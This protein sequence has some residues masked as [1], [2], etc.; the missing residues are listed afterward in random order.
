MHTYNGTT[1]EQLLEPLHKPDE[2]SVWALQMLCLASTECARHV[3]TA[4]DA[5]FEMHAP[6]VQSLSLE[7]A[8]VT[9]TALHVLGVPVHESDVQSALTLQMLCLASTLCDAQWPLTHEP[10][11]QS[12]SLLHTPL[13]ALTGSQAPCALHKFDVQS[14]LDVQML[15]LESTE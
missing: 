3:Y 4:G 15:L 2:Q 14:T 1:A 12:L 7:H 8:P 9:P 6:D 13:G 5:P 11:V 10:D